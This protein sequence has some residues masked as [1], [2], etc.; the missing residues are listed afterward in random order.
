MNPV[1]A[2]V[3]AAALLGIGLW[4]RRRA[5]DL[6]PAAVDPDTRVQ[7]VRSLRRGATV[8]LAFAAVF[9]AGAVIVV[10]R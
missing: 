5:A 4:G 1:I 9:V 8:C 3:I 2:V 7:R 6:V 10:I